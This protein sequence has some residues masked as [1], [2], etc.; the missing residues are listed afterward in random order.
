M[1]GHLYIAGIGLARGYIN[2]PE[3]TAKTF[4]PNPFSAT[5]GARMYLSGDLARYLPDGTI[6]YLGRSDHQVKIRGLRIELGEI[7]AALAALEAVRDVVV[8]AR[9]DERNI[10]RL[11][12]YLVAHDGQVLP[13]EAQLRTALLKTLPD[14]MVPEYFVALDAM[15]LT[16]NGKVER[17]ALPAPDMAQ[18][19]AE[20]VA[21]CT[22]TEQSLADIWA[23]LLQV[24]KVGIH[25]DFFA[26]GGHSLLATQLMSRIGTIFQVKVSLRAIF[27]API[28]ADMA[29]IVAQATA[30]L[31]ATSQ[32]PVE[33]L[34][35]A[36][37]LS[38]AQQ[39]LWF[40][41]QLEGQSST[42]NIPL[43]IRLKGQLNRQ[44]LQG[45]LNDVVHR[46]DALRAYFGSADGTPVQ[47]IMPR[48]DLVLALNDL[49]HSAPQERAARAH[50]LTLDETRIPFDLQTGPLIRGSLLQLEEQEYLL[51][52]TMHHIASDGWSMGILV[53]EVSALYA[54]HAL[55]TPSSLPELPMRYVDFSRWQRQWLSGDVLERQL[56]YWRKQLAGS[57][58][59]LTLPTDRPRPSV[60]SQRGASLPYVIST[61]L[62][63]K[64]QALSRKTQSTLFMTLCTAFNVL[65]ARYSGQSDICIGTPIA[66]RNRAEIEGMIGFFV[67]TLVLRTDVD[68]SL[69][70]T[71]LLKQ[72]RT[73]TLDAYTHQDVQFEQLVEALQ[74]ERDTSYSPLFQ[75]MLVLQNAPMTKLTLPGL[76]LELVPNEST[77][78][79]FDLTL[80]LTEGKDGLYGDF[81][82]S[83]DLFEAS[84]IERM[85][86]HFTN[87]LQAIVTD[88]GCAVGELAMLDNAERQQLLYGF[89]DT[90]TVYPNVQPNTQTLHQLFEA[91]VLHSAARTAV[92]YEG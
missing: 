2:R 59:L 67:N 70:F 48:L 74:P 69:G 47:R 15:P 4:I 25:D 36:F 19:E 77:T 53:R 26:L 58:T 87:L 1:V 60:Q 46:H 68:L 32:P 31:A 63:I 66:N 24:D 73:H 90:A 75:V 55:G 8:L 18:R 72:V 13:E 78:A 91:Q 61:E 89:N 82:Y 3:L 29:A 7:E 37:P 27:E 16:A 6:E 10:L 52:L 81:E 80:A 9:P 41:D 57:P 38:F 43:A 50:R 54:S 86:G 33:P 35:E 85:A 51:L 79:K 42:Y 62:S 21:P 14:Y 45:A 64:L 17:K 92:V 12:A 34:G 84:T 65:L 22:P 30:E 71:A 88:P 39:R 20:Y 11:V 49:R 83:T 56:N 28:L 23:D 44:A 76:Q 40:L 5:P